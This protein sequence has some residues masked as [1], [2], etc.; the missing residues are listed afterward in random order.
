ML[1]QSIRIEE[2]E[3]LHHN[4]A[5]CVSSK[6]RWSQVRPSECSFEKSLYVA[7]KY[8]ANFYTHLVGIYAIYTCENKISQFVIFSFCF[9]F[10]T[11]GWFLESWKIPPPHFCSVATFYQFYRFSR[12]CSWK[13]TTVY[14]CLVEMSKFQFYDKFQ[15]W[16]LVRF[17]ENEG[18]HVS[19]RINKRQLAELCEAHGIRT[20]LCN[21]V[22]Y[23][24]TT[25]IFLM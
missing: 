23:I 15:K 2:I 11:T 25:N 19:T 1:V 17:L 10:L 16:E 12:V 5:V 4:S 7:V 9:I 18:V 14:Y 8:N 24:L 3:M 13:D 21:K 6:R 22:C 20:K